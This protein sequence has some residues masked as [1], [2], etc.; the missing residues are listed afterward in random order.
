MQNE[1]ELI[2]RIKSELDYDI[3]E[4]MDYNLK[5]KIQIFKSYKTIIQQSSASNVNILFAAPESNSIILSNP[6]MGDWL[7]AK[8]YEYSLYSGSNLLLLEGVGELVVDPSKPELA[9]RNN[10]P[11]YIPNLDGLMDV[12]KQIKDNSIW[13]S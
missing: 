10:Y 2:N 13:N 1:L 11:W 6:R 12:L 7:N 8:C 3:I 5:E 4:L 9:D